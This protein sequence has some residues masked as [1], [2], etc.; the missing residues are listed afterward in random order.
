MFTIGDYL[1]YGVS[2][3]CSVK[4]IGSSPF[5]KTDSRQYYALQP[6]YESEESVIWTPVDN[7]AVLIR[8][9]F[10]KDDLENALRGIPALEQITVPAEKARRETYRRIFGQQMPGDHLRILK[11]VSARRKTLG[12]A[13]KRL[14]D[15]DLDFEAKAKRCLYAEI[16]LVF[17]IGNSEARELVR[18]FAEGLIDA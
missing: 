1:V 8:P 3:V 4:A 12:A 15:V 16:S 9:L 18:T 2:G 11:T 10:S 7:D 5:D 13:R 6:Y 14:P 17:G